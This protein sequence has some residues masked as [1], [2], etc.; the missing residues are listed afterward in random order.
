MQRSSADSLLDPGRLVA[1]VVPNLVC[2]APVRKRRRI[3]SKAAASLECAVQSNPQVF[4]AAD[5][6]EWE[7]EACVHEHEKFWSLSHSLDG[8]GCRHGWFK[9]FGLNVTRMRSTWDVVAHLGVQV[10]AQIAAIAKWKAEALY[11]ADAQEMLDLHVAAENFESNPWS[12]MLDANIAKAT[13]WFLVQ[14]SWK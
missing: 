14:R 4:V 6:C 7:L 1:T 3:S 9:V 5:A 2:E 8:R 12:W 11:A 10:A 13:V